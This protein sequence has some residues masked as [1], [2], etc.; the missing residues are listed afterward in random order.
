MTDKEIWQRIREEKKAKKK[1]AAAVKSF[2][3]IAREQTDPPAWAQEIKK[4][5]GNIV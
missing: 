5:G 4:Q 1:Q 2:Q 3:T